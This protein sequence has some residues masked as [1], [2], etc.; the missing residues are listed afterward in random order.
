MEVSPEVSLYVSIAAVL[1]GAVI[2]L[3]SARFGVVLSKFWMTIIVAVV[4]MVIAVI[5]QLPELPVFED[6][7]QYIGAWA[8][9]LSVYIGMATAIYNLLLSAVLDK[10]NLTV[11][12][13]SAK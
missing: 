7:L 8:S 13:F 10:L 9:L 12:R 3:L 4:S 2:R 1:L 11:E 5:A 6:P